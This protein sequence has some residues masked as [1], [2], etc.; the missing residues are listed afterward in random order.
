MRKEVFQMDEKKE[1]KSMKNN[2]EYFWMYYKLPF[3]AGM[4]VIILAMYFLITT[5]TTKDTALSVMLIDCH[6]EMSGE[7]MAEEYMDTAGIDKKKYQVQI[8]RS[9]EHTSE[10][11]SQPRS[12]MPSS[13]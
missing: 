10:L 7:E 11:Q 1:K 6:T 5:L 8:Q 9:E 3:I 12:R 13:A 4:I 2:L